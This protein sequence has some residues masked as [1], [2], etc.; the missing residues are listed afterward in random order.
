MKNLQI[1]SEFLITVVMPTLNC[2][3]LLPRSLGSL[4]AQI[5]RDFEVIIVDGGSNDGTVA[6][7]MRQLEPHAI[8][9]RV[10]IAPGL[11]IYAAMNLGMMIA[12]G[13]WLYFLGSD[14]RL[15]H[16]DVFGRMAQFLL[17]STANLVHGEAWIE[18]PGYFYG[19]EFPLRRLLERNISHQ[20]IFYRRSCLLE[21]RLVYNE[22]YVVY[23]DWDFNLRL[24]SYGDFQFV[25][26][27]IAVYACDGFS[28][29]RIDHLFMHEKEANALDYFGLRAL[30]LATPDR[31]ALAAR[32]RPGIRNSL[33]LTL[34][35]ALHLSAKWWHRH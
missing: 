3:S 11:G 21:K 5:R 2:A 18:R 10:I 26:E 25:R 13:A 20:S 8:E 12:R 34:S 28:A 27:P 24:L 14:D 15:Y 32:A 31:F 23:A 17:E 22:R 29:G 19:G 30:L 16:P 4:A 33:A 6:E 1:K 9:C 35:R 7:A